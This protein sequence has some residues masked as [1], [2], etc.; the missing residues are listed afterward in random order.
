M[1]YNFLREKYLINTDQATSETST[2]VDEFDIVKNYIYEDEDDMDEDKFSTP[3][4]DTHNQTSSIDIKLATEHFEDYP[5][6]GY[7][8]DNLESILDEQL[9]SDEFE[10]ANDDLI[11]LY[12]SAISGLSLNDNVLSSESNYNKQIL[13]KPTDSVRSSNFIGTE[14][15]QANKIK[16]RRQVEDKVQCFKQNSRNRFSQQIDYSSIQNKELLE[17]KSKDD[18]ACLEAFNQTKLIKKQQEL[19]YKDDLTNKMM[20]MVINESDSSSDNELIDLEQNLQSNKNDLRES[21]DNFSKQLSL[22]DEQHSKTLESSNRPTRDQQETEQN[23][24]AKLNEL[25]DWSIDTI[26]RIQLVVYVV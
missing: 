22:L 8:K 21:L 14:P 10:E 24:Q 23:Y 3:D 26:V 2:P 4:Y 7:S 15:D 13:S 20:M 1:Q 12:A 9:A 17:P 18:L 16:L 11:E 19:W 25:S 5:S 6:D